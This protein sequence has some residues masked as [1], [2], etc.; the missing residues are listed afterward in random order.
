MDSFDVTSYHEPHSRC[1]NFLVVL[2]IHVV[3]YTFMQFTPKS[4]EKYRLV[5]FSLIDLLA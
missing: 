5:L 1:T 2:F 4:E 3:C